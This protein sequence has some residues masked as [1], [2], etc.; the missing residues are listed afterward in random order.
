[1]SNAT[2]TPKKGCPGCNREVPVWAA[3]CSKCGYNFSL[4]QPWTAPAAAASAPDEAEAPEVVVTD[5]TLALLAKLEAQ[6]AAMQAQ[7]NAGQQPQTAAALTSPTT[8]APALIVGDPS[9]SGDTQPSAP[10]RGGLRTWLMEPVGKKKKG[11]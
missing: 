3:F 10:K 6:L 2:T 1:M 8:G 7:L 5:P 11:D 9:Q 4:G